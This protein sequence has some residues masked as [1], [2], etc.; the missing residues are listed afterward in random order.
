MKWFSQHW[1]NGGAVVEGL[2][3]TTRNAVEFCGKKK[4]SDDASFGAGGAR[5]L[6]HSFAHG[7][8]GLVHLPPH[9]NCL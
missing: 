7:Q 6:S 9:L 4:G 5:H 8:C 2:D 1:I 3:S